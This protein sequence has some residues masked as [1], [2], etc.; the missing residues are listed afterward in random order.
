MGR[1]PTAAEEK[2]LRKEFERIQEAYNVLSP[3]SLDPG[4]MFQHV[5]TLGIDTR[6]VAI[7]AALFADNLDLM[8]D[9]IATAQ[10]IATSIVV[11]QGLKHTHTPAQSEVSI[12]IDKRLL[13]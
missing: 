13:Q 11:V 10:C 8:D 9:S 7:V 1:S 3:D 12:P 2:L 5:R 6:T 4:L